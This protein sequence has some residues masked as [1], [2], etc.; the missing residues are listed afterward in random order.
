MDDMTID[1]AVTTPDGSEEVETAT[2]Q[3]PEPNATSE[4]GDSA[5]TTETNT[6]DSGESAGEQS[7]EF[8]FPVQFNHQIREL[9][10]DETTDAVQ[11]GLYAEQLIGKLAF[12][13]SASGAKNVNEFI[14]TMIT[15]HE[16]SVK[17][18][19]SEE[20]GGNEELAE[21]LMKADREQWDDG[22]KKLFAGW[23]DTIREQEGD[24]NRRLAEQFIELQGEVGEFKSFDEVPKSVVNTAIK[25]NISLLDAYLRY[26][27][28]Q[29]KK[30]D[31]ANEQQAAAKK[32]SAGS[33]NA[34]AV[35]SSDPALSAALSGIFG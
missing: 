27:H 22:G 23:N 6:D 16:D 17:S 35:S 30:T 5:Q 7:E 12:L 25:Q 20:C 19:Y 8:K 28:A 26:R 32:A 31:A 33:L 34:G 29:Q 14:D 11:K 15:A 9:T 1:T 21:K 10:L 4:H 18:R 2:A 24:I 3:E 13:A